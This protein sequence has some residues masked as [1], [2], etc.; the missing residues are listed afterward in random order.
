MFGIGTQEL[1]IIAI[2]LLLIFGPKK[3]PELAKSIGTAI[4]HLKKAADGKE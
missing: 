2:V 4:K 3:I 1:V